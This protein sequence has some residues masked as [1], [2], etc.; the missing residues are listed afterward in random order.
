MFTVG[1]YDMQYAQN[2]ND[3]ISWNNI[4]KA[5]SA[6]WTVRM[7]GFALGSQQMNLYTSYAIIDTGSSYNMVPKNDFN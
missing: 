6:H 4:V 1:G 7:S 3:T 5:K 2:S